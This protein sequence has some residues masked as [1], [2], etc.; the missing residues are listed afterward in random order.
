M[1]L[2]D[3]P[4]I[5]DFGGRSDNGTTDN[6]AA[7]LAAI[8]ETGPPPPGTD[9]PY[10]GGNGKTSWRGRDV[11][12]PGGEG[13]YEF[14]ARVD[15]SKSVH[16]FG[17]GTKD[18][19]KTILHFPVDSGGFCFRGTAGWGDAVF[20]G[21]NTSNLNM[22][23]E[24]SRL[25]RMLIE[26]GTFFGLSFFIWAPLTLVPTGAVRK[27]AGLFEF[28]H[29]YRAKTGGVTSAIQPAWELNLR[30]DPMGP[31]A[32][33]GTVTDGDV[34]WELIHCP[35]IQLVQGIV[36]D[37]I[38]VT[39]FAGN[40]LEN[41]GSGTPTTPT[42]N[43]CRFYN[44]KVTNNGASGH[45][46]I[47]T[48]SSVA[49]FSACDF[50]GN[51]QYGT[52]DRSFESN[53]YPGCH[54]SDNVYGHI[55]GNG[56]YVGSYLEGQDTPAVI[57]SYFSAPLGNGC[58]FT[59]FTVV[60]WSPGMTLTGPT[61]VRPSTKIG[62]ASM[63][64][65]LVFYAESGTTGGTE[66]DWSSTRTAAPSNDPRWYAGPGLRVDDNTVNNGYDGGW[67]CV[68]SGEPSTGRFWNDNL[69]GPTDSSFS[70]NVG[71]GRGVRNRRLYLGN[72][73]DEES[74]LGFT[75][76]NSADGDVGWQLVRTLLGGGLYWAFRYNGMIKPMMFAGADAPEGL[77]GSTS[78][79]APS[80]YSGSILFPSGIGIRD[81][82]ELD[83][84]KTVWFLVA[85]TI[86]TNSTHPGVNFV[87]GRSRVYN[88]AATGVSGSVD[89]WLCTA[90]GRFGTGSPP[91][92]TAIN[93]P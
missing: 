18:N 70:I 28:G 84:M 68:G 90:T 66:P 83:G 52:W 74:I 72:G 32:N 86:P 69:Q 51:W 4:C 67:K 20:T 59:D 25:S 24:G 37:N 78:G 36:M 2:R 29:A 47:G 71:R 13:K 54:F 88:G 40:G 27:P 62:P 21:E 22:T 9:I 87:A 41:L 81:F 7:L 50:E 76:P 5:R 43:L 60:D 15:V 8:A 57:K 39:N 93:F 14:S 19:P 61:W 48:D 17:E 33:G 6:L 16:I 31:W 38:Y 75:D 82:N 34:E 12:I 85:D 53:N 44:V 23:S 89:Y 58:G 92:F 56:S 10:P 55:W 46:C 63:T 30:P 91:T 1:A 65:G 79:N 45:Y 26:G 49:K 73:G 3:R 80:P 35:G 77:V 64:E 11:F 42:G